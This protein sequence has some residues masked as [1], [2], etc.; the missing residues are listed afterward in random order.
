MW[1][2]VRSD[3][4]GN[5]AEMGQK[6]GKS[7]FR[8]E[9]APRCASI[10]LTTV[11]DAAKEGRKS[12]RDCRL[13]GWPSGGHLLGREP[14]PEAAQRRASARRGAR[15]G[16][17]ARRGG[18]A[19]CF[20]RST[21][22][23]QSVPSRALRAERAARRPARALS[24][25]EMVHGFVLWCSGFLGPRNSGD[26]AGG[27][28][29]PGGEE[30][31]GGRAAGHRAADPVREIETRW[32]GPAAPARDGRWF[33][34]WRRA[35]KAMTFECM[36][37]P[38]R[39]VTGRACVWDTVLKRWEPVLG[40]GLQGRAALPPRRICLADILTLAS[41]SGAKCAELRQNRV[42]MRGV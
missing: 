4:G 10:D 8:H 12:S 1:T 3:S 24:A 26:L 20:R 29:H 22:H 18:V 30:H 6:S 19:A 33:R 21:R 23:D 17:L 28:E 15:N 27:G 42:K 34:R 11:M 41:K 39:M 25:S 37:T 36:T 38:Q 5:S 16:I 32:R 31:A 7:P 9:S 35:A 2:N 14:G 40:L 13:C